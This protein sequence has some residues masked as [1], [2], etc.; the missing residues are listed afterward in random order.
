MI[1]IDWGSSSLRA[2]RLDANGAAV[3]TRRADLGALGHGAATPALLADA[4]QGWDDTELLLCGMVGARGG[5][6]EAPYLPCPA[7][8]GALAQALQEVP[9]QGTALQ[10]RRARI[11]PGVRGGSQALPDVM[12]GEET[13]IVGLLGQCPDAAQV[14]LPGTHSK[15][16]S[17]RAGAIA[18]VHTAMTGESYALYRRHSMLARSMPPTS[19]P[20]VF[21]AEAFAAGVRRSG[22][23]GGL[24]HHLFGVRTLGLFDRL[25]PAQAPAYLSGLL[26]G[27]E[28]R[29]QLPLRAPVHLIGG[30]TLGARYRQAFDLLGIDSHLHGEDLAACGLFHLTR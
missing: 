27:H 11:V 28:V 30:P 7:T 24:L 2:W 20:E 23:P 13:Q 10:G 12:R 3:D 18:G 19:E 25:V 16:V 29:A 21:D 22:E 14:C 9:T 1:A 5:W 8:P 26:I 17:L 15:W 4:L 6:S